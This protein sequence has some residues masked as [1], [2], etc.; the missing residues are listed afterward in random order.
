[1][2]LRGTR[3]QK[4]AARRYCECVGGANTTL[5]YLRP[6]SSSA[7]TPLMGLRLT[8]RSRLYSLIALVSGSLL[9]YVALAS[10][11]RLQNLWS[12]ARADETNESTAL[13]SEEGEGTQV[14]A[15]PKYKTRLQRM[16]RG[17]REGITLRTIWTF[18]SLLLAC[19]MSLTFLPLKTTGATVLI[20]IVG[21]PWA[22]ASWVPFALVMEQGER[23]GWRAGTM[24]AEID[25]LLRIDYSSRSRARFLALRI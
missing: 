5:P 21:V 24:Q 12:R 23:A 19:L 18:A 4:G 25:F 22:V 20:S 15:S 1:M 9:P 3:P 7:L 13:L 16:S 11:S 10:D 6:R 17:V 2:E 8:S 14:S